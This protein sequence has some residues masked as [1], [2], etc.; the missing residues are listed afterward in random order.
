MWTDF[1][2]GPVANKKAIERDLAV[3]KTK[4]SYLDPNSDKDLKNRNSF[5]GM[6]HCISYSCE[7][8]WKGFT[9]AY[10]RCIVNIFA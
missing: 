10:I 8:F 7:H 1:E 4:T 6:N 3:E 9:D 2:S 5:S